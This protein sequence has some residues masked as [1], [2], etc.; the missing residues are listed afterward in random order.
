MIRPAGSRV[1]VF[2]GTKQGNAG[3]KIFI[4]QEKDLEFEYFNEN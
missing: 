4:G 3:T 1:I 2:A